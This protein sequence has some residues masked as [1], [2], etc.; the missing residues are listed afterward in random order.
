MSTVYVAEIE[1]QDLRLT[2]DGN[3]YVAYDLEVYPIYGR[4]D[5]DRWLEA[6]GYYDRDSWG[7]RKTPD[8]NPAIWSK[9]VV[10]P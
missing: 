1:G 2:K 10:L 8:S 7:W 6:N 9:N 4:A 3:P 5:A